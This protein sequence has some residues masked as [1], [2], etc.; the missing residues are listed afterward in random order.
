[1]DKTPYDYL[2]E[3][4]DNI[5]RLKNAL[6]CSVVGCG[7]GECSTCEFCAFCNELFELEV[8]LHWIF[9]NSENN[10]TEEE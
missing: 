10:D 2:S 9:Y 3:F 4:S 1:M 6:Y 8:Q 5:E 7:R